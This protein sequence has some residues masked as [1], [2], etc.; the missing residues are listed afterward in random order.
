MIQGKRALALLLAAVLVLSLTGCG[1]FDT[2]MARA[3][4]KMSKLSSLRMDLTAEMT[5]SLTTEA[6]GES[7]EAAAVLKVPVRCTS[8][9]DIFTDPLL[10]RAELA[11]DLPGRTTGLSAYLEKTE[12][13][14]NLYSLR[15]TGSIWQK[16]G[17][18]DL[19]RAKVTGLKYIVQG[20]ET[21]VQG[22]EEEIGGA[23][24]VRYDGCIVGEYLE[25]LLELY[26]VRELLADGFGLQ[27]APDLFQE[28]KDVPASLWLDSDSGMIVRISLDLTELG[29][30]MGGKQLD[31][32]RRASDFD[33]LGLNIALESFVVTVDLSQFDAV[34]AF[35]IPEEA[36]AAWG[37]TRQPWEK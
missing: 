7:V 34:E 11:L 1:V 4:Q 17:F 30:Q 6:A 21:F 19:N 5:L 13:C 10:A 29:A 18:T 9:I 20:A 26:G 32:L 35:A 27:L 25:G 2:R 3:V 28:M 8:G 14:Y 31:D 22:A 15:S 24:A 33:A 16:Q 23:K 36:Q 37:E 12:T